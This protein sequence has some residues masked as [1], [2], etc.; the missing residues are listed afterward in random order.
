MIQ[1]RP[2]GRHRIRPDEP[3]PN[4][5]VAAPLTMTRPEGCTDRWVATWTSYARSSARAGDRLHPPYFAWN[6]FDVFDRNGKPV[7]DPKTG[8]RGTDG[9][10]IFWKPEWV[11]GEFQHVVQTDPYW[12]TAVSY[13]VDLD[14]R[15]ITFLEIYIPDVV[16]DPKSPDGWRRVS[17][18]EVKKTMKVTVPLYDKP[19]PGWKCEESMWAR[20]AGEQ[21]QQMRTHYTIIPGTRGG[22]GDKPPLCLPG[23]ANIGSLSTGA[24]TLNP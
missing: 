16:G 5:K 8:K 13:D 9:F 23:Q 1:D 11:G 21:G 22:R 19:Q 17:N 10:C 6:E 4:L 12:F 24:C 18:N 2:D 14:A 7:V 20:L 15:T 3:V